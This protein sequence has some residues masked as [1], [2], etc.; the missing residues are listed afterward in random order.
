M[1]RVALVIGVRQCQSSLN[2]LPWVDGV[3]EMARV[4]KSAAGFESVE[5]LQDYSLAE[6]IAAVEHFCRDR[7]PTD[8]VFLLYAGYCIQAADEQL[9]LVTPH[10]AP[11]EAGQLIPDT[12][13]PVSTLRDALNACAAQLQVV[14]LDCCFRESLRNEPVNAGDWADPWSQLGGE[15]RV[16]LSAANPSHYLPDIADPGL[17][18]YTQYLAEGIETGAADPDSNGTLTVADAHGYAVRKLAIAAPSLELDIQGEAAHQVFWEVPVHSTAD[19]YRRLLE[20]QV[21][22]GAEV[23]PTGLTLM[24]DRSQLADAQRTLGLST[25]T[26]VELESQTLRPIWEYRQR[27]RLYRDRNETLAAAEVISGEALAQELHKFQQALCLTDADVATM[28]AN[29]PA[30]ATALDAPDPVS[31]INLPWYE[32]PLAVG[33]GAGTGAISYAAAGLLDA[34][35]LDQEPSLAASMNATDSWGLA[36]EGGAGITENSLQLPDEPALAGFNPTNYGDYGDGGDG[37]DEAVMSGSASDPGVG[38]AAGAS[39]EETV[40]SPAEELISATHLGRLQAESMAESTGTGS[41]TPWT[42]PPRDPNRRITPHGLGDGTVQYGTGLPDRG[43]ENPALAAAA[44]GAAAAGMAATR[45]AGTGNADTDVTLA[46]DPASSPPYASTSDMATSRSSM[47]SPRSPGGASSGSAPTQLDEPDLEGTGDETPGANAALHTGDARAESARSRFPVIPLILG[48]L[49][50]TAG[51]VGARLAGLGNV[52]NLMALGGGGG[53]SGLEASQKFNSWGLTKARQGFND[54]AIA[55]YDKAVSAD[56][57]NPMTYV[58]RG[59]AQFR[60]GRGDA[61]LRDYDRA[62]ELD[63]K[64][65]HAYSN[66]SHLYYSRKDYKRALDDANA[67]VT[68][69]A[70]LPE[71]YVNLANARSATGDLDG[72]LQDYNRAIQLNP[73]RNVLAGAFNNRG[74]V[75][76]AMK[77]AN[78]AVQNYNR[79]LQLKP[80]MPDSFFNRA[81]AFQVSNN[82]TQAITDFR[83][84]AR[85][86]QEQGKADL[87]DDAIRRISDLQQAQ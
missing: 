43:L 65:A 55:E 31:E 11:D 48:G 15:G 22:Q 45:P 8:Q 77:N 35:R 12:A 39:V 10:T 4:L 83:T 72:A 70:R 5:Y 57:Q 21:Q 47:D 1:S 73:P 17:W 62:I 56:P 28:T 61:A 59:V 37:N 86:Y 71:A 27:L 82:K 52:P 20:Q 19:R 3:A 44:I 85:L 26:A 23:D 53:G 76:L 69:N 58:N 50:L 74:N 38:T 14:A 68:Y 7:Q 42:S 51:V 78:A 81:L 60:L 66:R 46:L 9:Y 64:L 36:S 2:P 25:A 41:G 84:A 80:D 54:Q 75:F 29:P 34:G 79:A 30:V 18:S 33:V 16:L 32:Q 40:F 87:K 63:P 49:A 6:T 67:A 13:L 24:G